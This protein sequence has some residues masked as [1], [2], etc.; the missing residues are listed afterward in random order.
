MFLFKSCF[1]SLTWCFFLLFS[2][3]QRCLD[4]KLWS[5]LR[6]QQQQQQR[7]HH[8]QRLPLERRDVEAE[9]QGP[10]EKSSRRKPDQEVHRPPEEQRL[11][12]TVLNDDDDDGIALGGQPSSQQNTRGFKMWVTLTI[13]DDKTS[14][15]DL[16]TAFDLAN[17]D[18]NIIWY[19]CLD[20]TAEML[21]KQIIS[22]D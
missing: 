20:W 15:N 9:S 18:F 21:F 19:E 6:Q 17:D 5:N 3:R 12:R 22:A 10:P 4:V 1:S 14:I 7:R 8:Q 16:L 11:C 13:T 2:H